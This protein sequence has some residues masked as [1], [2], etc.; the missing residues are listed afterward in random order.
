MS[1]CGER[2]LAWDQQTS[3]NN[4]VGEDTQ[5]ANEKELKQIGEDTGPKVRH[6]SE[7]IP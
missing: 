5:K 2:C 3:G 6:C 1:I 7:I 4:K